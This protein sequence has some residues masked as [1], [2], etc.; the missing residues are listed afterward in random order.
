[1]ISHSALP[2][3]LKMADSIGGSGDHL[4]K[5][6]R[7]SGGGRRGAPSKPETT[8]TKLENRTAAVPMPEAVEDE[9]KE[10][11]L[12]PAILQA[13]KEYSHSLPFAWVPVATIEAANEH[14]ARMAQPTLGCFVMPLSATKLDGHDPNNVY[15][16]MIQN[17]DKENHKVQGR[18]LR[19]FLG[20]GRCWGEVCD[21]LFI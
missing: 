16:P 1:M 5:V 11:V 13:L 7:S 2:R 18:D 12:I 15:I 19:F 8:R 17:W 20:G 21:N 6:G 4:R 14:D 10:V 9:E 3:L